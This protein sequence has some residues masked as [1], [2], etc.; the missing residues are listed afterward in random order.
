MATAPAA[1]QTA[2]QTTAQAAA[3]AAERAARKAYGRLVAWLAWQ[4]R[5]IAAAEDALGDALVAALATW[6]RD[7][8][9]ASPQG[10]LMTAAKRN[11]LK[12]ARHQRVIDDPTV[13]AL[14][15]TE[16]TA[17]PT[18]AQWP[19]DRLRLMFVCAHPAIDPP[20]R[21]ALML[22]TVLGVE[23]APRA[24]QGQDQGQRHPLRRTRGGRA[25]ATCGLGA[26]GD[27]RCL[28]ARLG[29]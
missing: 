7:G 17:A 24:R 6:P 23:A 5:D 12:A 16:E 14:L 8:V 9:P 11:L 10:W 20:V 29:P 22:Q 1:S 2:A 27:L 15:P 19:D 21:T 25:A 28:H 26:G 3:R 4:W 13:T 18:P